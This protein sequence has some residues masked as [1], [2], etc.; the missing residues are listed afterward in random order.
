MEKKVLI[1]IVTYNSENFIERCLFSIANQNYKNYSLF[2]IDNASSDKTAEIV[3]NYRNAESRI[4]YSNF[5]FV[6]LNKNI[7]FAGAINHVVFKIVLNRK[8][9][10]TDFDL[11][12]LI[13]P[14]M[15]LDDFSIRN[16]A[17]VFSSDGKNHE[18]IA[19]TRSSNITGAA[20]GLILEYD[21]DIIQN[22]GGFI[23]PNYVTYHKGA[24]SKLDVSKII[25]NDNEYLS[26]IEKINPDYITGAFFMTPFDLFKKLGGFDSGYRPA[27]FEELDYC[28]KVRKSGFKITLEPSALARH[29]EGASTGKFSKNFY[30]FYHKN[31]IR[32]VV[33]NSGCI[34]IF[35]IFFSLEPKWLKTQATKDQVI[36]LAK[37]YLINSFFFLF[38]LLLKFRNSWRILK[39]RKSY[40]SLSNN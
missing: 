34:N 11:I 32:C 4:P 30:Y 3:K 39:I 15:I 25:E 35:K 5:R 33:V 8:N 9:K 14:D 13:N 1:I 17:G 29:F 18:Q 2:V 10:K 31:R 27:Y 7:G 12:L 23:L 26:S 38:N 6:K 20:G 28:L 21:R 19:N 16:L 37:A 36:P 22:M 24:G 40:K